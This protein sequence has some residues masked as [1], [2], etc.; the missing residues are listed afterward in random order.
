MVPR[1]NNYEGKNKME[2]QEN[3]NISPEYLEKLAFDYK[4]D[5]QKSISTDFV[6]SPTLFKLNF[7]IQ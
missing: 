4:S 1:L 6:T 7:F 5:N 3:E 2:Y